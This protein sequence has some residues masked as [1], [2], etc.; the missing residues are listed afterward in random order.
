MRE[1]ELLQE[2]E[3]ATR[4]GATTLN[5][6]DNQM[7]ALPPEIGELKSLT[8]LDLG[9]NQLTTLL[10]EI[11]ELKSLTTLNLWDNQLTALPLEIGELKSLTT[12]NLI[13]NQLTA[14][15]LE[16]G[17]LTSLTT[18]DLIGNQLT[19]LPLEIAEL[20]SL[21]TLNLGGNQL[22]A[23]PSELIEL[24]SLTELGL[25]RS[26]L[27]TIPSEIVELKSLTKL[28]LSDNQ[29]TVRPQEIAELKSLTTLN[30]MGN[31]LTT[32][33]HE[34]GELT[35]LTT[36][37]LSDN[38]LTALPPE[39]G[40]LT[41]LTT[42]D[43]SDNQMIAL[44]PEIGELTSLTALDLMD[45]QLTVLPPEIGKLTSLTT[46]NLIGN[47]L[48][49]LPPEI[50]ELKSLPA[51]YLLC[52]Q[53]TTL[54]LEIGELTSLTELNLWGNQLT[55][56]PPE[57]GELK[58]LTTLDL[59]CNQL[60]TLPLE[61]GELT[62]LTELDLKENLLP[63]PPEIL[64]K[65]DEPAIIINYYLQHETGEKMPLNEAKM[66]L[67]G[68]GS[69]GKTSLVKRLL[70]DEFDSHEEKTEG[71]E[72]KE[73]QVTVGDQKIKLNMWDFGGQEIMHATH[74]FFLTKRSLYLLVLDA[75]LGDEENRIEY[76][77][78]IIKSFG[79]DSPVIIV[80]N[81]ID[82]QPLDV[83][84]RGLMAKYRSI[85]E[86]VEVSCKTGDG[87]DELKDIISR[88]VGLLEHIHDPLLTTWS[89][90]KSQ[91]ED[92]KEDYI[93]YHDYLG[94][95]QTEG[96]T[97]DLSQRTL[98]SLLHDLGIVLNF[99]DDPRLEDTNILNPEWVT[100]GVYK[101][102]NYKEL[103]QIGGVLERE[104][105]NKILGAPDYPRDKQR[106]FIMD[107]MRKFELCFDF[108]GFPDQRF[109][110][111]SLL[112]KEEPDTGDWGDT[113]AFQY[114]Y[115]VLPGSIISRFIVRMHPS[116]FENT[117]WRS[118]VVL[119]DV[120]GENKALVK[121][122]REDKNILIR[123][124]G[125]DH[126]R[127]PFLRAI[128]SNFE[129]IHKTTGIEPDEKVPLP[130]HPEIVVGYR[131]LLNL[132]KRGVATYPPEGLEGDVNVKELL[133]GVEPEEERR[134]R[135]LDRAEITAGRD[136]I[137]VKG[138]HS[139]IHTQSISI[140]DLEG[141][142]RSLLEFQEG[143]AK[144]N[145]PTDDQNIVNGDISAAIKEANK[146]N[147][148]PSKIRTRFENAINAVRESG[149]T[150]KDVSALYDPATK[151]FKLLGV[152][153]ALLL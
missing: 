114:H 46:L 1:E 12:L 78:K 129:H 23:L 55:A 45:N 126:T 18:L 104:M 125:R 39:I 81:K 116:I 32:L 24:K 124:S 52:N 9:G 30:L 64:A 29:L 74:Q 115:D 13:G 96:V 107:M 90:V 109:L 36:L 41:S 83:D 153:S 58:S 89:V 42:L 54:P 56:L 138:D 75:R 88:E 142:R 118:G 21:T 103:L 87:I 128:R 51:L 99:R 77:L 16:I 98:I 102:L 150:V 93:P 43:L 22:T 113:L 146:G 63:I 131:H 26:Q 149:R 15:P 134:D 135:R 143:L 47:Q 148:E 53:L 141:I 97:D 152:A 95:C 34:I 61:I 48:T 106:M 119:E 69:V 31:Q 133:D 82:E 120:D 108:D 60:T 62:S 38:Q 2:I 71:I 80:G 136:V 67:V 40:E 6:S 49:A 44:P 112:S 137:I 3:R 122:D 111:P 25:S 10:P 105:L 92:M 59:E 57:I 33:P 11:G 37:D 4:D 100:N 147:P 140:N 145:L 91:L 8:T 7:I 70:W 123:I 79:G 127:R 73:W 132:E 17:E 101:I 50:G 151:I 66:L 65:T 35:S 139:T 84:R 110:I 144:L 86:I 14:L 94:M 68:Q 121:A 117:Y 130:A 27:T 72:I 19:A 5:L 20:K 85:R 28:D 76:W